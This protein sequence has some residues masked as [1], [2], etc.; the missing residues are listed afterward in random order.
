M[1]VSALIFNIQ[2]AIEVC[3]GLLCDNNAALL[4]GRRSLPQGFPIRFAT[5][6]HTA[7]KPPDDKPPEEKKMEAPMFNTLPKTVIASETL[8]ET[9][10]ALRSRTPAKDPV[11]RL[12][13]GLTAL[14][15]AASVLMASALP[16]QADKK[17][18]DLA[19]ALA[20]IIVIGTIAN[21]V[22]NKNDKK[23]RP[24]K[25]RP[26]PARLPRVPDVCAIEI[27]SDAGRPVTM[28]TE[29][30]MRDEG[31]DYR[32][33]NCARSVRIYGQRDRIYS[34]QCL[35]DAGFKLGGR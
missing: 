25:V 7:A 27:D 32:L 19:K 30:C 1:R 26:Q 28:Y 3:A 5:A 22:D 17:G 33:P 21:A 12:M 13:G 29:S 16:S 35:R 20:A 2:A 31:F 8:A 11:K 6:H 23:H 24:H 15:V 9:H 10:F 14:A 18:D 34:A 4:L